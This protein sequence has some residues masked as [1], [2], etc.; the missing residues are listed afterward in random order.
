VPTLA[1][2]DDPRPSRA[3]PL[4]L[5][6][7]VVA[8]LTAGT[9]YVLLPTMR[10][11]IVGGAAEF[12]DRLRLEDSYLEQICA[13]AMDLERDESLC[14]CVL[15]MEF[16]SLDCRGPFLAW[17]LDRMVEACSAEA[18]HE[19]SLSF[20]S[21]VDAVDEQR[22]A[23]PDEAEGRRAAQRYERCT[24]LDDALYLPTVEVLAAAASNP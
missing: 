11:S 20:C 15:A 16:P 5:A 19:A 9:G 13:E 23:A 7:L 1:D 22:E 18:T 14:K 12:D 8:P 3:R 24:E 4:L 6:A 10:A 21:C 17:S 2:L